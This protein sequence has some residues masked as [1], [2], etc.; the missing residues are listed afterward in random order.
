MAVLGTVFDV[1]ND[2]E[3][4]EM[5]VFEGS[6]GVTDNDQNNTNIENKI[7]NL[8]LKI[9]SKRNSLKPQQIEKPVTVIQGP[10]QVSIDEWLEIVENQK[11]TVDSEGNSTV[12]DLNKSELNKDEW[13]N[14]NK[15][16][17]KH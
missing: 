15:N 1:S 2:S 13:V 6:V 11:I 5:R 12:S 4:T 10:H 7:N 3:K 14:W 16:L 9:D 8:D 17:D